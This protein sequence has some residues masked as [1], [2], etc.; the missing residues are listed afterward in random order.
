MRPGALLAAT[1]AVGVFATTLEVAAQHRDHHPNT[2]VPSG[3]QG[4]EPTTP[5]APSHPAGDKGSE[6]DTTRPRSMRGAMANAHRT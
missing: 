6:M 2:G 5:T 3:S 1:I 4:N